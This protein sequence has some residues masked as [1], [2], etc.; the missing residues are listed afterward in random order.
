MKD[1][2]EIIRGDALSILREMEPCSFDGIISDP[3]YCIGGTK[4]QNRQKST[5]AKYSKGKLFTTP[6]FEGDGKDQRSWISWMAQWLHEARRVCVDGAPACIFCDWRQLPAATDALQWAGWIW[7]GIAVWDKR[8][9]RPQKGRFTQQ[10]EY[11]VWGS[12]GDMPFDRNVK[13]LPG[14]FS[15]SNVSAPR[16]LHQT[17]KPVELMREIVRIVEPG[18]RILDPFCGAGS[19]LLAAMLEG[20][21]ATGIEVTEHYADIAQKRL[22]DYMKGKKK[23]ENQLESAGKEP[24]VL[25]RAGRSDRLASAGIFRRGV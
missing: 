5:G 14:L 7:R 23:H 22:L 8:N 3:P 6:D 16:R 25:D 18:G 9:A 1:R 12:K 15:Y 20:Y 19:T 24:A 10:T 13:N 4:A 21:A 11:I 17:E 2:C